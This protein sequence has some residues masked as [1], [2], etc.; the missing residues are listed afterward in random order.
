MRNAL[1]GRAGDSGAGIRLS[2][3]KLKRRPH[4]RIAPGNVAFLRIG[5]GVYQSWAWECNSSPTLW[6]SD[7]VSW[8]NS[9]NRQAVW[10]SALARWNARAE[11]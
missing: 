2:A 3:A 8:I 11:P 1:V 9:S 4:D 6:Q 7:Q 10:K 5:G